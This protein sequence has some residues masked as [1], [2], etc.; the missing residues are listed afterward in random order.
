MSEPKKDDTKGRRLVKIRVEEVSS[1]GIPANEQEFL[2]LKHL[3]G[4]PMKIEFT[5]AVSK[6][7]PPD[8]KAAIQRVMQFL[9]KVASGGYPAPA[10][11][12]ARKDANFDP[13]AESKAAAVAVQTFIESV[14]KG[15]TAYPVE[16]DGYTG[17]HDHILA[18]E[19]LT[20]LVIAKGMP[21]ELQTSI[22]SL[23]S[24]IAKA[25]FS[26]KGDDGKKAAAQKVADE[27]K[28]A[29]DKKAKEEEEMKD[30]KKGAATFE[31][32]LADVLKAKRFTPARMNELKTL[33]GQL[34]GL[35]KEVG[36]LDE[37]KPE[38]EE[39]KA[40]KAAACDDEEKKAEAKKAA[41]KKA[42]E[43]EMKDAKKGAAASTDEP[44]AWA[45]DLIKRLDKIENTRT[46]S[47]D[48]AGDET[49]TVKKGNS[50]FW[51]GRFLP[52]G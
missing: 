20:D 7:L 26:D 37:E 27:E 9:S 22:A 46:P 21:D 41:D 6:A 44:P 12:K 31:E 19:L 47:Q 13:L 38:D 30:A 42:E 3:E 16:T 33:Y 23:I 1:V 51:G 32:Q 36:A 18:A 2:V 25:D 50:G 52:R 24:F 15:E 39:A 5:E 35:L 34:G 48:G 29:A 11:D 49:E 45:A 14:A 10:M 8:L 28:A 40:K 17:D 43:D 4:H